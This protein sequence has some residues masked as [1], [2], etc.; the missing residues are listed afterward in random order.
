MKRNL[1]KVAAFLFAAV[2]SVSAMAQTVALQE[3]IRESADT[4]EKKGDYQLVNQWIRSTTAGNYTKNDLGGS[5]LVRGIVAKDS[6]M[7]FC[8]RG[9]V[10]THAIIVVDGVSGE[11]EK[12]ILLSANAFTKVE[13]AGTD[14]ATTVSAVTLANNDIKLDSEGNF[15]VGPCITSGAQPMQVYKVDIETGECTELINEVIVNNPEYAELNI[16]FDAFGVWGDVEDYAVVMAMNAN[17]M[18]AFR[19]VIE[20]GVAGAAELV[21]LDPLFEGDASVNPGSTPQ[22][23]PISDDLFYVDGWST[24][25]T[26]Y[27]YADGKGTRIDCFYDAEGNALPI[28]STM[29]QGHN[30]IADFELTN[31]EGETEYFM[32]CAATNTIKAP[33]SS[34]A[35]IKYADE[36][37]SFQTAEL[38][39][40]FPSNGFGGTSNPSRTAPV[41]VEVIDNVAH[42]YCYVGENGFGHYTFSCDGQGIKCDFVEA[43]ALTIHVET[44]GTLSDL[45]FEAGKR[46]DEVMKLTLTGTLND[47]DFTLM[48]KTMTS[49]VDVNL[50]GITNTSGVNFNSKIELE[51]IILPENLTEIEEGAF[52]NS[53]LTSI[54]IP[55]SVTSI[56]NDAFNLSNLESLNIEAETP[57]TIEVF[58]LIFWGVS[59][60][61]PVTIPCGT[62]DA[63]QSAQGWNEFT[64]YVEKLP[65]EINVNING[66]RI[67]SAKITKQPT[68]ADNSA[69]I[70][71]TA[72]K[73]YRFMK[74]SDG[75]TENP[76]TIIVTSDVN[77]I[78]EFAINTYDVALSAEN[79]FVAGS[80]TYEHGVQ[81]TLNAIPNEGYHFVRWSDGNTDATR[82]ITV[83]ENIILTAEFAI[84]IY[85]IVLCA[86]NGS[87][88]GSGTYKHGVQITLNAVANEG[89]H[90]V[91]WSDGNTNATRTI[92]VTGDITLTAEFEINNYSVLVMAG[93]NGNVSGSGNFEYGKKVVIKAEANDGYHFVKWS[94]D[95]TENPRILTVS[96]EIVLTAEFAINVYEVVAM[97]DQNGSVIGAGSYDHGKNIVLLATPNENYYFEQWSDGNTEN[98]RILEVTEDISLVA[99]FAEKENEKV[100][101]AEPIDETQGDVIIT[102]TAVSI[103]GFEFSHWS[104]G[105][106][107]NPRNVSLDE[108][109]EL[110]AYFK[111]AEG[112]TIT[113]IEVSSISSAN[114]YAKDGMLYVENVTDMYYV[115]DAAAKLIYTGRDAMLSLPRG[116][117]MVVVGDEVE[118][119]VL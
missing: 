28:L 29:N 2:V 17:A 61:I 97:S 73:G 78:A 31:A 95:N 55:K 57:P 75:N 90:F 18:N 84:N 56:G 41:S 40:Q 72:N 25:P 22:I 46:P 35:I 115:L 112:G 15:L 37:L 111:V 100:F 93:E 80:G 106:M 69:T 44:P 114:I 39:Y 47:D 1:L 53:S 85:N 11:Y 51:N 30:G 10:G 14:S 43:N 70:T 86:E 62:L 38:I 119:V 33:N 68:C 77:L 52:N 82:T 105:S 103:N 20:D 9:G 65:F 87:V 98:P 26:L 59:S 118:K 13:N 27:Q 109:V 24:Y 6:K 83:T 8:Y 32:C 107:E 101:I 7:Y 116:V 42:L 34:F 99:I 67:G 89:Y 54:T 88:V 104:D 50:S 81:I 74:W 113:N 92:T 66:S 23:M 12:T 60:N 76:R 16:R 64:N 71:A 102:I 91:R 4:Y 79:G 19:W 3:P 63:Y 5:G 45:I 117:Y 58:N 36:S 49:L 110:Y 48:R 21:T 96:E 108:S 94:D